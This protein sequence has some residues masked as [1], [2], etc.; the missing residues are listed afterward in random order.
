MLFS[1]MNFQQEPITDVHS[2]VHLQEAELFSGKK[3]NG[4]L[5]VVWARIDRI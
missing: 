5:V 4:T 3:N 1:V 2:D